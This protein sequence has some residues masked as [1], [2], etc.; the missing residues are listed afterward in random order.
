[1]ANQGIIH[2]SHTR[3]GKPHCGTRRSHMST[4]TEFMAD[5]PRICVKCQA[6]LDK[7]KDIELR[8]EQKRSA[9]LARRGASNW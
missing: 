7:W 6:V 3:G 8:R 5:W 1:M 2:I 9:E 4:T